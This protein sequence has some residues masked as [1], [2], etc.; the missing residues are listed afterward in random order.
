MHC[1]LLFLQTNVY[2]MVNVFIMIIFNDLVEPQSKLH[3]LIRRATYMSFVIM[4]CFS[5][6]LSLLIEIG[7]KKIVMI[8]HLAVMMRK[9][10]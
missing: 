7:F 4:D 9:H 8:P 6:S 1:T 10:L 2:R 3:C 5:E